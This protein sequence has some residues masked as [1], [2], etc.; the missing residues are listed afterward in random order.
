MVVPF[1]I[2][3]QRIWTENFGTVAFALAIGV[4]VAFLPG[5]VSF[6]ELHLAQDHS[7]Y[8]SLTGSLEEFFLG[9]LAVTLSA[10]LNYFESHYECYLGRAAGGLAAL[11]IMAG[12]L[13]LTA[14][15]LVHF[16]GNDIFDPQRDNSYFTRVCFILLPLAIFV[17][18]LSVLQARRMKD[19]NKAI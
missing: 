1:R 5:F 15:F 19:L 11:S 2:L 14:Y 13:S 8:R 17:S 7:A 9:A 4:L 12:I 6:L 18:C 10:G 3:G 16:K